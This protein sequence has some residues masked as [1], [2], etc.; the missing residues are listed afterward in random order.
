ML[1]HIMFCNPC[2]SIKH[3]TLQT[4]QSVIITVNIVL[5]YGNSNCDAVIVPQ[6]SQS[7]TLI[8]RIT[9]VL[10]RQVKGLKCFNLMMYRF[11]QKEQGILLLLFIFYK[12]YCLNTKK[13]FNIVNIVSAQFPIIYLYTLFLIFINAKI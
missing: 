6:I 10:I 2:A 1:Q 9:Y 11:Y 12:F 5:T 8:V 4:V 3:S 13:L 7:T